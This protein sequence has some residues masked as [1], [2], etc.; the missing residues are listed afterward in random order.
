MEHRLR[1]AISQGRVSEVV[2]LLDEGV[3]VNFVRGINKT[4]FELALRHPNEQIIKLLTPYISTFNYSEM[5]RILSYCIDK[6]DF[7]MIKIINENRSDCHYYDLILY[8]I[9]RRQIDMALYMINS[10]TRNNYSIGIDNLFNYLSYAADNTDMKIIKALIDNL[11]SYPC[12]NIKCVL[13]DMIKFFFPFSMFY[14]NKSEKACVELLKHFAQQQKFDE[15]LFDNIFIQRYVVER[16]TRPCSIRLTT[17]VDFLLVFLHQEGFNIDKYLSVYTNI[18]SKKYGMFLL[19]D[20]RYN[21]DILKYII[22]YLV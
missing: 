20:D 12:F 10:M 7:G 4:C 21:R 1:F 5:K 6:N 15:L 19:L 17:G 18:L 8:V 22:C 2:M 13:N 14:D 3:N 11:K 16:L 9:K